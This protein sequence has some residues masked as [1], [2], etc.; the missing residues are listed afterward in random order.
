LF[1]ILALRLTLVMKMT[2]TQLQTFGFLWRAATS[3]HK[4][5]QPHYELSAHQIIFCSLTSKSKLNNT[6]LCGAGTQIPGISVR[7]GASGNAEASTVREN[8]WSFGQNI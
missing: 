7:H 2:K 6:Y 4:C 5:L 8:W 1:D 3:S